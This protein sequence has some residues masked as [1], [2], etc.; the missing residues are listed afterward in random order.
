MYHV[1][2]LAMDLGL[3]S[4]RSIWIGYI[5]ILNHENNLDFFV[6]NLAC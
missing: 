6:Y 5:I 4:Y 3:T 1:V 2:S